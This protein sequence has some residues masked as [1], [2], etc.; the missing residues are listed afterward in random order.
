[1]RKRILLTLGLSLLLGLFA[2][3]AASAQTPG[4]LYDVDLSIPGATVSSFTAALTGLTGVLFSYETDLASKALGNVSIKQSQASLESI[5]T[6]A[7]SGKGI[8]WKVVNRTVVL[9]AEQQTQDKVAQVSGRVVDANGDP[10][11]GAGVM[12]QGTTRGTTTDADG[13]YLGIIHIHD[14]LREGII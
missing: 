7:F 11:P 12:I 10:L 3:S 14:I 1:M 8:A 5:L 13:R 4:K 6:R 2:G 9:T